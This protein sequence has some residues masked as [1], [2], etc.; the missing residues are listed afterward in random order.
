MDGGEGG[1]AE[2]QFNSDPPRPLCTVD[3][4]AGLELGEVETLELARQITLMEFTLYRSIRPWECLGQAWTKK[5]SRD[6]KAP[7][8]MAMIHRFN[9]VSRWVSTEIL[10]HESLKKRTAVLERFIQ[11]ATV[12]TSSL[13]LL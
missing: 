4:T 6:E 1:E 12:I 13:F 11:I 9:Q 5:A 2:T 10:K 7:N 3:N 8:I